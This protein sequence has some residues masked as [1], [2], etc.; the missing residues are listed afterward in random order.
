MIDIIPDEADS[1]LNDGSEM[2]TAKN[3]SYEG[4]PAD[5]TTGGIEELFVDALV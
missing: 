5:L 4:A 1:S 2:N 3:T